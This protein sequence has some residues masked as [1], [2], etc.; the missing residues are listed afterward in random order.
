MIS[1]VDFMPTILDIAGIGLPEGLQGRSFAPLLRGQKQSGRDHIIKEYN[2]NAGGARHPMRAVE[3]RRFCYIF[4]PWSNGERVFRT[5]TQGTTTYKLMQ[6]LAETD[7]KVAAR[8]EQFD[9]RTLEEF[10]DIE[11]DRDSLHNLIDDPKHS[12]DIDRLRGILEAWMVKTGDPCLEVFRRRDDLAFRE[13]FMKEQQDASDER[14]GKARPQRRRPKRQTGLIEL[15]PPPSVA[16]G[17]KVTVTLRHTLSQ[18]H[19]EQLLHVTL[20]NQNNQRIERKV[21]TV[22]G[23]GS[24]QVPF[25]VPDEDALTAVVFAAFVGKDFPSCLQHIVSQPV[26]VR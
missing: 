22:K 24:A 1:A 10:Y 15:T 4:N 17:K 6:K 12:R 20:K 9:H 8:L 7:A 13:A 5:A 23:T 16:R 2:E 25:D 14:R 26:P 19:G 21:L 3:T 11:N 18:Q